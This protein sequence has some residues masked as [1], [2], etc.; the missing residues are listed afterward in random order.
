[1]KVIHHRKNSIELL[2]TTD[3]HYGVEVDIRS[4]GNELIIHHDPFSDGENFE[5]WITHYNH[6]FLILNVKEEGLETRLA[7]L[8][9][10]HGI[11]DYFFLD[12]SFPFLIKTARTGEKRCAVRLSEF[13]SIETVIN[14][15][16]LV[17]WVWV[18]CFTRLPLTTLQAK[19]LKELNFKLCFVSPELQGI[20]DKDQIR[21]YVHLVKSMAS[22]LDA[23]CTKWPELWEQKV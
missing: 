12:Q 2:Q 3:Q 21:A 17:D 5:E 20:S 13:E 19:K 23:V 8:M 16:G 9:I 22:D 4:N 18:D 6:A 7:H 11:E 15:T 14:M 10:K 1:M